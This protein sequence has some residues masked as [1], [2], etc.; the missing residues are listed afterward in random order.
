M[1]TYDFDLE[2]LISQMT[3]EEKAQLCSGR[4]FWHTQNIDRLNIPSLMMCDGP[5][6]LRKQIGE[7]DHLGINESIAT[8]CYPTASAM[9]SSFDRE[10]LHELGESLGKECRAERVAMLLGPGV[11]MKRSPLC[12]R[13]FEY[14]SEDPY[15]AGEL[16]ASYIKGLQ[17]QG[18]AACVKHF[19]CNNQETRRMSGSSEVDERTLHEI[20]LPAFEKCVNDGKVRSVMCGYN[21][22]NGTF[23]AEN[24]LLN[25]DILRKEWGFEGFVVTDWGAVKDRALGLKAGIDLE[26]PGATEGKTQAILKALE[27][28]R[29][30]QEDLD[31]A[32]ENILTFVKDTLTNRQK[33]AS[34]DDISFDREKAH[35]ISGNFARE[36]AVLLSND[37]ILP[38]K[39]D[40][41]VAFIGAFA[42]EPRYQGAG[43]SHINVKNPVSALS[44]TE[45][46]DVTYAR[47][48]DPSCEV[49]DESLLEEAL[50][51]AKNADVA[52]IFAGLPES[53]ETEGC[54]REH[55]DMPQNQN[56]L[57]RAVAGAAKKVVVV[58]HG[59][60]CASLP[61]AKEVSA[62]LCMYL[63]GDQAGAAAVDLLYGRVN[64][65]G[66]LAETWP[67]RL[68][69]NPSY[70][71]FPGE[72]G[73]VEYREGIY[74]GYRYYDK[75]KMDVLFP[76]GHGL[77]YTE[78]M[79]SDLAL[80]KRTLG[81]R[82]TLEVSC[83]V[84]NT[85]TAAGKEVVQ[86]YAAPGKS[87]VR[88]AVRELKGFEKIELAPE[89]EK[90]VRFV[91]SERDFAYYETKIHDW[92]VESGMFGIEIGSSS[93]DI[94]LRGF[95]EIHS[96]R[97]LPVVYSRTSTVADLRKTRKGRAF[98][99]GL[100]GMNDEESHESNSH[101]GAGSD[102]MLNAM[103]LEM[104]LGAF[105]S[106]GR[107]T[108]AQLDEMIA[109]L[110]NNS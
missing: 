93:R 4:D 47:G 41:K 35:K 34:S 75:K 71:N 46:L 54:D 23:C 91:L 48:Y 69:D 7:G 38:L 85:G 52:V 58:Y 104:P 51:T 21:A 92:F 25:N 36:C 11:N 13:N 50:E 72:D 87:A 16:G 30:C 109:G 73:I 100:T 107:M 108:D 27:E 105:V 22:V 68:E 55:M 39:D 76:F 64:P 56:E 102:R 31:K 14:F 90:T 67:L 57:I 66:K 83:K 6:G 42:K 3:N 86:L 9:A 43:S 74:I 62:I 49:T 10:L 37:G 94:R 20:Y 32:V 88:R 110:N 98:F 61:W 96:E 44:Y 70:L 33:A 24:G 12:G 101:L 17:E 79:Y 82:D 78:F 60:S 8:V 97:E 59:G 95:V 15:L 63:A 84:K 80:D 1:E 77:S 45:G 28:G 89:E 99:A 26:M 53:Y 106:Y 103:M 18:V 5:N 2:N 81:D 29:I 40:Q 65:S 19:A